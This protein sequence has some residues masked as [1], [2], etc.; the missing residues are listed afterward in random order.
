MQF[1]TPTSEGK[2]ALT[3]RLIRALRTG[4]KVLWLVPGGSNIQTA[5][6]IMRDIP[7]GITERLTVA[8]TDERFGPVGHADSNWKQLE[9]AGFDAKQ[10]TT[11]PILIGLDDLHATVAAYT[12]TLQSLIARHHLIIGLFG[13][14]P[15]GHIAGILP[16]S[17]AA[18]AEGLVA[19]Y[20]TEQFM[21][22]TS[23]FEAIRHCT[24]AYVLAAGEA[25]KEALENLQKD[26]S[27]YDQP[28]QILKQLPESYIFNDVIGDTQ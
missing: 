27:P 2:K 8:L 10:A 21:R 4:K 18:S 13:M 24:A 5:V 11:I 22:I 20:H 3:E 14:G 9:D 17:P 28:A 16:Q 19:G 12:T 26:L 6:E 1:I 25:K 7:E 15:D 23:T